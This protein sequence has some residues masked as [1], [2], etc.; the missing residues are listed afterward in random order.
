MFTVKHLLVQYDNSDKV[1]DTVEGVFTDE[2]NKK[3]DEIRKALESGISLDEF[4]DKYVTNGD[5]QSDTVFVSA[6]PDPSA[7]P[8]PDATPS[9]LPI[10]IPRRLQRARLHHERKPSQQIL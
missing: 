5:Y 9:P 6:T 2:Q 10:P 3:L 8:N 4:V 7:T 1:S